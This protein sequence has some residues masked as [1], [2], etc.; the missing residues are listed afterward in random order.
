MKTVG[1]T[2]RFYEKPKKKTV[3]VGDFAIEMV[4]LLL[5]ATGTVFVY[6]AGA[7][8]GSNWEWSGLFETPMFKQVIFFPLAVGV[9]LL[10]QRVDYHRFQ[11]QHPWW[12]SLTPYLVVVSF[13]LLAAVLLFGQERNQSKRWLDLMPGP[14]YLSFQPSELAK[15]VMILFT[16]AY[17]DKV[18]SEIRAFKKRFLPICAI[19]GGAVLLIVIED[20]GTA[21]FIALI[22][23]LMLW[24]G[25][26]IWWHLLSPLIAAVPGFFAAVLLSPTRINRIKGF[27]SY[28][29]NEQG[30]PYQAQQS[31]KAISLGG[32]WGAGLGRGVFKY[33][34]LPE[35]TTDFIFAVIA[36]EMGFIGAIWVLLLFAL[37]L[38]FGFRIILRCP[39]RFGKLLS[40]GIVFAVTIQAAINIGVVTVVLPTKGI[41]LPFVSAGGTSLLLT[42]AAAGVLLN[43]AR[44]SSEWEEDSSS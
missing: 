24:I 8:V 16:A 35:D 1:P 26:A 22:T 15:W 40:A 2:R 33:G 42:A 14:G 10:M 9:L 3:P 27:F 18:G 34:H 11:I 31:L 32:L 36:E 6:S 5:M 19:I 21:A 25:G 28:L 44:Q 4:V 17:L 13:L 43:I 30:L 39:D 20:F 38:I 23:F 41:P 7:S 37:F 12:K 29:F